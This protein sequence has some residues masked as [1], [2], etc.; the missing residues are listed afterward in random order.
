MSLTDPAA[1]GLPP[2]AAEHLPDDPATLR[3]MVLEL[4]AS[5][6]EAQ[7][8]NAALRHRLD[9]LLRRLY[10]PRG[11][12]FDPSQAL[13]FAD[14]AAGQDAAAEPAPAAAAATP[15]RRCR[16]HGR[17]RLPQDLPREPRHH[18]LPDPGVR[19][20]PSLLPRA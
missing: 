9:L 13:L 18:E 16:P 8:D 4:L 10:G 17:R 14:M 12:R 7:R 15:R 20:R 19:D 2:I 1:A 3:R 5:L 6:H 11:E